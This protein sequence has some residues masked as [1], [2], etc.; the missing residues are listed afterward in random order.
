VGH[1]TATPYREALGDNLLLLPLPDFGHGPKTGM[2]SWNWGITR[3][4]KNPEAAWEV[5]KFILEP[6]QILLM[7]NANGAVPARRSVLAKS[8]LFGPAGP[9]HL[10][11]QQNEAGFTVP[12]PITPAYPAITKAFAEAFNNVV[13]GADVKSQLDQA[14]QKIDQEIEDNKG[15]PLD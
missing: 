1:W 3:A 2:G 13:Q 5:L 15:Y 10:Y 6:D 4:C 8:E 14:V 12:R 11:I 9:L 7:T